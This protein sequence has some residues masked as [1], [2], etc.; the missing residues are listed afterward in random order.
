MDQGREQV[1]LPRDRTQY[2]PP[3]RSRGLQ[4][5]RKLLGGNQRFLA[6]CQDRVAQGAAGRRSDFLQGGSGGK[7]SDPHNLFHGQKGPEGR[8]PQ[9]GRG[10]ETRC[11]LYGVGSNC[12]SR[13]R[14]LASCRRIN[15]ATS[16]Q[17]VKAGPLVVFATAVPAGIT[18]NPTPCPNSR[19]LHDLKAHEAFPRV[20]H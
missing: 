17:S 7:L 15:R 1:S 5:G 13:E 3:L 16:V 10:K 6:G 2:L 11:R 20:S 9:A 12:S 4:Q 8:V 14:T 18:G 19:P